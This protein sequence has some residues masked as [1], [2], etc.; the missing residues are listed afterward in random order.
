MKNREAVTKWTLDKIR[1]EYRDDVALA[2]SHTTLRTDTE[3]KSISYFIPAT[4]KGYEVARTF[5]LNGEGID[6]WAMDWERLERIANLEEYYITCLAD[7]EI[8][9]ARNAADTERFEELK[10]K[11]AENLAD[12]EKMKK[13]AKEAYEQARH[14]YMAMIFSSG[15]DVK[16]GA[17]Y[18]LDYLAQAIAFANQRYFKGA[19]IRQLE[20]LR[21]MEA[22]PAEF[23]EAYQQIIRE[24]SEEKQK[25]LCYELLQ[26]V[27]EFL[28][29]DQAEAAP[30]KAVGVQD[31]QALADWYAELSYTW[32]RIRFYA[33]KQD[34]VKVYMW[35]IYLQDE[36]NR[37]CT[38]YGI[39]KPELMAAYDADHLD[40]FVENAD[41]L[42]Q[43]V[44]NAIRR[45]GGVIHEYEDFKAFA[46]D[47]E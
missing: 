29:K 21:T 35:G 12:S 6:I 16:L 38:E 11:L 8:L 42:E 34:A 37:V 28:E 24:R 46:E 3:D 15:S 13:C 7:G 47:A 14:V 43:L 40:Q 33:E 10:K 25:R 31:Y 18:V 44:R 27:Q 5:I 23:P 22:V 9:Y 19:Q 2:V 20:E 36:L 17:G 1:S 30:D 45:G 32:Y 39:H 4:Q 41:Q 26:T